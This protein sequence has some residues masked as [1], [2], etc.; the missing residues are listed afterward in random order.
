MENDIPV[1]GTNVPYFLDV[2]AFDVDGNVLG[3]A[4]EA[5]TT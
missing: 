3:F 2:S 5:S 4:K 1:P